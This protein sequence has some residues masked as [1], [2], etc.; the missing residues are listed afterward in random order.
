MG[1]L[2]DNQGGFN[3]GFVAHTFRYRNWNEDGRILREW[4][5]IVDLHLLQFHV[6]L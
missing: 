4:I 2:A 1:S 6:E 5:G 3:Q